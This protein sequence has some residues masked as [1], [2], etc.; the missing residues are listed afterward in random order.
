MDPEKVKAIPDW[1]SPRNVF[2]VRTFH[3][4]ASFYRKFI[5]NFSGICAPIL[6]IVKKE[7]QPF[8]WTVAAEKGFK[9]LKEKIIQKLVLALPEFSKLF[10]V[11]CDASGHAIGG[12]LTQD[13]KPVAYFSEKLDEAK[14]KYSTY[15]K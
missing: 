4:L 13:D 8:K 7:K 2:E 5:R 10:S 11:R 15:D 1:Q 14:Q 3:G 6:D 9:L 12:V